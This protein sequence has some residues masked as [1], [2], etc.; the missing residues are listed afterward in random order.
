MNFFLKATY[1]DGSG[2]D[3]WY[4]TKYKLE[5]ILNKNGTYSTVRILKYSS[6][7]V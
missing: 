6:R 3:F 1:K 2:L 5:P 4:Q 7:I